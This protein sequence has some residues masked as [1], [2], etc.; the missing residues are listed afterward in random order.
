MYMYDTFIE[1]A[2]A[3]YFPFFCPTLLVMCTGMYNPCRFYYLIFKTICPHSHFANLCALATR[4]S[5][6]TCRIRMYS[7]SQYHYLTLKEM[8]D[9]WDA[10]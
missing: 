3:A 9:G 2:S 10:E 8:Q 1:L 6:G 4:A 7:L 5:L